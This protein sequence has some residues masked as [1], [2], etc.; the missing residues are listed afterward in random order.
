M[1]V[2]DDLL[3][4]KDHEWVQLDAER[5]TIKMGITDFAQDALGDVV[6]VQ[7]PAAGTQVQAGMSF[8]EVESSKSVS[9]IYAAVSGTVTQVN[10]D[11]SESPQRINED[12]YGKGW[13][14]VIELSQ[15]ASTDHLLPAAAYKELVET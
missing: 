9:D 12:P 7:T 15:D 8:A 6:F 13:I 14:C 2:P 10:E 5:R 11:L 1:N 3:Y 4:T